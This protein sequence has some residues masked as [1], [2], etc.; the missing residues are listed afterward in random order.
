MSGFQDDPCRA[1]T[2]AQLT[3]LGVGPAGEP[4]QEVT[5]MACRWRHPDGRGSVQVLFMDEDGNG[6]GSLYAAQADGRLKFFEE[7]PPVDGYPAVAWGV[8]DVRADGRCA[9]GVGVNPEVAF[10][11]QLRQSTANIGQ[12]DPC[13]VA[14]RV[15]RMVL[16]TMRG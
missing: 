6:L 4:A 7:L 16:R 3:E 12:A 14:V 8:S 1:L 2:A 15:A 9:V 13:E 11:L 10:S 5:G